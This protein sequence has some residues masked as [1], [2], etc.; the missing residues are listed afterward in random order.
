MAGKV[1]KKQTSEG[2]EK[3]QKDLQLEVKVGT[4]MTQGSIR[5]L[6]SV[7]INHAFAV[8]NVKIVEGT[9]GLFVSMP[10]YKTA[11]GEYKDIC[12]PITSEARAQLNKA[13]LD[14]YEQTLNQSQERN[15]KQGNIS[16]SLTEGA[17]QMAGM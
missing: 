6:A 13:V 7:N 5:A 11:N 2:M 15:Q 9:K 14:A 1:E 8:R 17:V 16:Q 10:S 3:E 4:I 12:F